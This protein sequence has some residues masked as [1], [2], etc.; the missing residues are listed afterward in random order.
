MVVFL[1]IA[2]LIMLL[3]HRFN[4]H[5]FYVEKEKMFV[6]WYNYKEERRKLT[7]KL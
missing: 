5:L 7:W 2:A 3:M 1:V 6:L 4:P